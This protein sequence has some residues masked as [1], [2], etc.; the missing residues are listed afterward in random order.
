MDTLR[1]Q[2]ARFLAHYYYRLQD[3]LKPNQRIVLLNKISEV[4]TKESHP[5]ITEI[6]SL[7]E[8]ERKLLLRKV[9]SEELDILRKRQMV[10]FMDII[11]LDEGSVFEKSKLKKVK[12]P[13]FL[14]ILLK[15]GFKVKRRLKG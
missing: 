10:L 1:N 6:E 7:F 14:K 13:K 12:I 15:F 5:S 2:R 9:R 3:D 4:L 8:R 11:K